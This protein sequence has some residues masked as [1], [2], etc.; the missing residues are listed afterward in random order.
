MGNGTYAIQIGDKFLV[1]YE[2]NLKCINAN[3]SGTVNATSGSFTGEINANSGKI[4]DC[5]IKNGKLEIK[6]ANIT[7]TIVAGAIDLNTATI[8]GTLD[9]SHIDVDNMTVA[10]AVNVTGTINADQIQAGTLNADRIN[11]G[12]LSWDKLNGYI[13]YKKVSSEDSELQ[14]L[15]VG[16]LSATD[17][18]ASEAWLPTIYFGTKIG[19]TT[20]TLNSQGITL[21]K[22]LYSWKDIVAPKTAVFG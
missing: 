10:N 20:A 6:N 1:D 22:V 9:V 2:G 4:G 3:V 13:P 5:T 7:D 8:T 12:T 17:I 14:E 21:N 15:F 11:A 16:D 19:G 18:S